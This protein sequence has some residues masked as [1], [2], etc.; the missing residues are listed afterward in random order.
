VRP[1][2]RAPSPCCVEPKPEPNDDGEPEPAATDEQSLYGE[3]EL[4]IAVEL[5]LLETSD[6]EREPSTML[7]T[8]EK[9]VDSKSMERGSLQPTAPWLR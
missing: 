7:A 4:R 1:Q 5:E 3:T 9:A 8:R 2:T 6:Q